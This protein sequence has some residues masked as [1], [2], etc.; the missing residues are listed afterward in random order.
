MPKTHKMIDSSWKIRF[1]PHKPIHVQ[2]SE[3]WFLALL[4][5]RNL[6]VDYWF[7]HLHFIDEG[8]GAENVV[9]FVRIFSSVF[10]GPHCFAASRK[11][12]HHDHLQRQRSIHKPH[13]T[14]AQQNSDVSVFPPKSFKT[15]KNLFR[16]KKK[17][18]RW[19]SQLISL[20]KLLPLQLKQT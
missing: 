3:R 15:P 13:S 18:K 1:Q 6:R 8:V 4:R 7:S 14:R 17:T 16:K 12:A 9:M 19:F 5:G 11:A 20:L 2:K 10:Q